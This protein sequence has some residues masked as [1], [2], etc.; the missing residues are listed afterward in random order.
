MAPSVGTTFY[1]NIRLTGDVTIPAKVELLKHA[2][3]DGWRTRRVEG[4]KTEQDSDDSLWSCKG[5]VLNSAANE[6]TDE[7]QR[8]LQ[9]GRPLL[10][11]ETFSY[12]FYLDAD[13][14]VAH[15]TLGRLAFLIKP[16]GIDLHWITDGD[17]EWTGLSADNSIT[18]PLSR[19]G[20]KPLPLRQDQWNRIEMSIAGGKVSISLNASLVY[21]RKIERQDDTRFG[22]F[23]NRQTGNPQ[24]SRVMV[25]GAAL[26][27]DW[28]ADIESAKFAGPKGRTETT[29]ADSFPEQLLVSNSREILRR[30]SLMI[31]VEQFEFLADWVLPSRDR[32]TFRLQGE[33][34]QLHPVPDE[35]TLCSDIGSEVLAPALALVAVASETKRLDEIVERANAIDNDDPLFSRAR[36][37]MLT[38]IEHARGDDATVVK[39]LES[40]YRL[41][42]ESGFQPMA[43][44]W[45][46]LLV[47]SQVAELPPAREIVRDL[48]TVIRPREAKQDFAVATKFQSLL[49][50]LRIADE[51]DF[52]DAERIELKHWI[53]TSRFNASSRAAGHP[54]ATWVAVDGCVQ[55]IPGHSEDMLIYDVPLQG[56]YEV[57]CDTAMRTH[58]ECRLSVGG[59]QTLFHHWKSTLRTGS[60]DLGFDVSDVQPPMKLKGN[61]LQHR[62]VVKDG[63]RKVYI[64]GRMLD[65]REVPVEGFPWLAIRN[66][67]QNFGSVRDL[68]ILGEPTIPTELNL[69]TKKL[70]GWRPYYSYSVNTNN[71]GWSCRE[72]GEIIGERNDYPPKSG[73]ENLLYYQ[74]PIA[75]DGTIAYEFYYEPG[76]T[77]VHPSLDRSAFILQPERIDL[78][79]VT[80]GIHDRTSVSPLNLRDLPESRRGSGPLPLRVNAWNRME[81]IVQGDTLRLRLNDQDVLQREIEPNNQR[82]FG[83]FY[84]ADETQCRVRRVIYRGD[85]PRTLPKPREQQLSDKKVFELDDD[86]EK[87]AA[88]FEHDFTTDGLPDNFFRVENAGRNW[89]RLTPAGIEV[90]LPSTEKWIRS[91]IGCSLRAVGDF[92]IVVD[93]SGL[94]VAEGGNGTADLVARFTPN[95]LRVHAL[96][97]IKPTDS[98]VTA[99]RIQQRPDGS[100][101]ALREVMACEATSGALRLA[102]RASDIYVLAS[103]GDSDAFRLVGKHQASAFPT[104]EFGIC[105]NVVAQQHGRSAITWKKLRIHA[106]KLLV[107]DGAAADRRIY[108]M[109]ADGTDVKPLIEDPKIP[110]DQLFPSPSVDGSMIAYESYNDDPR[111]SHIVVVNA[112][113]SNQRDLGIGCLPTFTPDGKQIAIASFSGHMLMK[114]DGSNREL[115]DRSGWS[116]EFSPDGKKALN[117]TWR[118]VNGQRI[119]NLAL[120]DSV[121]RRRTLLLEGEHASRYTRIAFNADWSPDSKEICFIG[122]KIGG[123]SELVVAMA[124]GSSKGLEVLLSGGEPMYETAWSP[125]GKQILYSKRVPSLA[126]S[127]LFLINRDDPNSERL[128]PGQPMDQD[129]RVGH[130]SRNG[131]KIFFTSQALAE[132]KTQ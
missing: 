47:A 108:V 122:Q 33:I 53:P 8:V 27:G 83:L 102:R 95:E 101:E 18:E 9:Y 74:R 70:I 117:Y 119:Q 32:P 17:N 132:Y 64:N 88:K 111:N 43:N 98:V 77:L 37:A 31:P 126:G 38:L 28:P 3:R 104:A 116:I 115:F 46:E 90:H 14:H 56:D 2:R 6:S 29:A 131:K 112:D 65:E 110:G 36:E 59:L 55:A 103:N 76:K 71:L 92:D 78:H 61:W 80:D 1:R 129:N 86:A 87:L 26:T 63:I 22:L 124:A 51:E 42:E 60:H 4:D 35:K 81:M 54:Q 52:R 45:P 68:R 23:D 82:L 10:A 5:G 120:I 41:T 84:F 91:H 50:A 67:W 73:F 105:L 48:I 20:P 109:N 93:Y 100:N 127:R 62:Y 19:R 49:S 44:R 121:T 66:P 79:S 15:P 94:A 118:H 75:E 114:I 30:A 25:R 89:T 40:L 7:A 11:G 24:T 21:Q 57:V 58:T 130:W 69:T 125:D 13:I 128:L 85:W 39:R 97:A 72:D 99:Q 34:S 12:E 106:D 96:R 107:K 113:G 123:G 16:D